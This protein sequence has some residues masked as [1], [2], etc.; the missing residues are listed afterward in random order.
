MRDS[1]LIGRVFLVGAGPGNPG[2]LTL[3][4]VECLREADLVV[5]DQLVNPRLLDLAPNAKTVCV[6]DLPGPHSER[7]PH[8]HRLLIENARKGQRVV[9]L[10]GGD[11]T[12][13][14]RGGEEAEALQDAGIP[15]EIVPGV[16]AGLAAGACAG[17]PLTHRTVS[18]AVAFVTGHECPG[19]SGASLDWAALARF[20]G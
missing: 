18:S 15:F 3:R 2:L 17:I 16:S 14:G 10:K 5:Y 7:H 20:P 6:A 12:V 9:R 1:S 4:A 13:F 8:V 11:P 19:K